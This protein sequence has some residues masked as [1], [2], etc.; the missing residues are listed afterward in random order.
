MLVNAVIYT[1]SAD[2]ADRAEEILRELR[3]ATRLEPGC[4][5][6]DVARSNSDLRIFALYEMYDDQA[7]LDAHF[8]SEHFQRLGINGVRTLAKERVGHLC[9]PIG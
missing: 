6:F 5:R 3:D 4:V 2:D 8:A 1:F 7:A 9:H